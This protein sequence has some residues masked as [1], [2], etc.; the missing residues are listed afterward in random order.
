MIAYEE[1][2]VEYEINLVTRK[3]DLVE[4]LPCLHV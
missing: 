2:L 3:C 1:R 4:D